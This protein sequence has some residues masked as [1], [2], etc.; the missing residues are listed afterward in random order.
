LIDNWLSRTKFKKSYENFISKVFLERVSA[1]Q[2]TIIGLIIGLFGAF[3]IYLS[4]VV[5][6]IKIPLIIGAAIIIG[7]SFLIDT[8]DGAI[9]RYKEPTIFGGILDIFCDRTVEI[10]I[11]ISIVSTD[12]INLLYPGLFSL[13]AMIL[14]ISMFLIVGGLAKREEIATSKVINYRRGFMERSETF[15]FLML[16]IILYPWRFIL[17]WI[18]ASLIFITAFLRLKDAYKLFKS[19]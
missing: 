16:I 9:A 17:L 19:K 11:I 2:L 15:V 12:S 7:I 8:F 1:N 6:Q 5:L 10:S 14:C 13:G 4:S 3:L 18:F